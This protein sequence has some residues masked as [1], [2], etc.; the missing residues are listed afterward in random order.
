MQMHGYYKIIVRRYFRLNKNYP[1]EETP[2]FELYRKNDIIKDLDNN[3][4]DII[5]LNN[6]N[7]ID[8]PV[9]TIIIKP[10]IN[11][12]KINVVTV[13]TNTGFGRKLTSDSFVV[14][15]FNKNKLPNVKE[16]IE[17]NKKITKFLNKKDKINIV[18]KK[19]TEYY[20]KINYEKNL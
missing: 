5:K 7:M 16:T 2:Q 3:N 4:I 10:K 14:L 11:S 12:D 1:D 6:Y 18:D 19:R 20:Y 15:R 17:N 8:R 9:Q 13:S